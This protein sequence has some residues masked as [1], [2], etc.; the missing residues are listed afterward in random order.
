M[1]VRLPKKKTQLHSCPVNADLIACSS[2]IL[3]GNG[4][5][6]PKDGENGA[7]HH[8]RP[9]R[10]LALPC[11]IRSPLGQDLSITDACLQRQGLANLQAILEEA[12]SSLQNV[13]KCNIYL[14]SLQHFDKMNDVYLAFFGEHRPVSVAS[15]A[16]AKII[17]R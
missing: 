5:N 4:W 11:F 8:P 2:G 15:D 14:D 16:P 1:E 9:S 10:S 3:C 12:G 13:V 6:R 17:L 7:G